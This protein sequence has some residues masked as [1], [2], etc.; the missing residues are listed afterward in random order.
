VGLVAQQPAAQR[1]PQPLVQRGLCPFEGCQYAKWTA[2]ATVL[3]V[4]NPPTTPYESILP[5]QVAPSFVVSPGEVVTAVTGIYITRVP[6]RARIDKPVTVRIEPAPGARRDGSDQDLGTMALAPGDIVYTYSGSEGLYV[7]WF[8]GHWFTFDD[9]NHGKRIERSS[10]VWWTQIKNSRGLTGWTN[11]ADAFEGTDM[12][13]GPEP[14]HYA[15][16]RET[17]AI[18]GTAFEPSPGVS[19][20][21]IVGEAGTLTVTELRPYAGVFS[22]HHTTPQFDFVIAGEA[23]VRVGGVIGGEEILLKSDQG[24]IVPPDVEHSLHNSSGAVTTVIEFQPIRRFDLLPP[25]PKPDYAIAEHPNIVPADQLQRVNFVSPITNG[26]TASSDGV[27]RQTRGGVTM[28]D[29]P[30]NLQTTVDLRRQPSNGEEFLYCLSGEINLTAPGQE[31]GLSA[32]EI[33]IVPRT[34][35]ELHLKVT[36]RRDRP[37]GARVLLITA[38]GWPTR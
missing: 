38:T 20:R 34:T 6:G 7:A 8:N 1:P 17:D 11:Q 2:M 21:S 15:L 31:Q 3:A 24:V 14:N 29:L 36:G 9:G 26:W 4:A 13:A 35:N 5:G 33:A 16:F 22:H 28:L 23:E 19:L 32:G 10:Y 25:R 18:D 12:L 27:R 30:A 37:T